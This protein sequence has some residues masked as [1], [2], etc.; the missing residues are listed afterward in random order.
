MRLSA[1]ILG[2]ITIFFITGCGEKSIGPKKV[3]VQEAVYDWLA[4]KNGGAESKQ[5][6]SIEDFEIHQVENIGNSVNEE[7]VGRYTGTIVL[8]QPL[9]V[10]DNKLEKF[11]VLTES[12]KS[13]KRT[14][15][16][17]K[18]ASTVLSMTGKEKN[19]RH[20]IQIDPI[21]ENRWKC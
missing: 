12:D 5:A 2:F 7:I 16:S 15:F 13:G 4:S 9:Y 1:F 14:P 21:T 19:W 3:V 6:F 20:E 17:G 18:Y 8:K 11:N 10:V